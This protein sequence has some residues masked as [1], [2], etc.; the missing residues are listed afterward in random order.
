MPWVCSLSLLVS[1]RLEGSP[2]EIVEDVTQRLLI[3]T[4]FDIPDNGKFASWLEYAPDLLKSFNLGE[5]N[6]SEWFIDE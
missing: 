1:Q 6:S 3:P 5:P 4:V 2:A